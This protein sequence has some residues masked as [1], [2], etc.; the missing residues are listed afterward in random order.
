MKVVNRVQNALT[1][2]TTIETVR[3]KALK[4]RRYFKHDITSPQS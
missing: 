4:R 1:I 2:L 3:Y